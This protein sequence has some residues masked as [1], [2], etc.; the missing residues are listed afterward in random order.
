[1]INKSF[2]KICT[3]AWNT[4]KEIGHGILNLLETIFNFLVKLLTAIAKVVQAFALAILALAGAGFLLIT[5]A[6]LFSL[7]IGLSDSENFQEIRERFI[8][9]AEKPAYFKLDMLEEKMNKKLEFWAKLDVLM[10]S[11]ITHEEKLAEVQKMLEESGWKKDYSEK[12]EIWRL[13][14]EA[15]GWKY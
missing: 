15:K 1:M 14:K 4:T 7:A 3:S 8:E 9:V 5:S 10:Q 13:L 6:Y 12:K 11:E 2:S